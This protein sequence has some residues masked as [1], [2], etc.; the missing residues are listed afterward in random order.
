MGAISLI[1]RTMVNGYLRALRIPVS[2]AERLA[3]QQ[4]NE[5]WPPSLAFERFE[6]KV[7]GAAGVVLRDD[8]LLQSATLREAKIAKLQEARTLKAAS[9]VER[10]NAR[11]KQRKRE[12]EITTQRGKA[13]RVA[14]ERKRAI[15][16]EAERK[17]RDAEHEAAKKQH[18]VKSQ[19]RAQ[20]EVI[21][22]RERATKAAALDAESEALDLTD[23]ALEAREK[24]DLIDKTLEGNKEARKTG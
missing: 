16:N 17:K 22:R 24:V 11:D 3:R 15:D 8:E 9:D 6:A 21:E 13:A 5:S 20:K 23:E 18:A 1:P 10:G 19:E 14:A 2:A 12:A 7:E 4:G